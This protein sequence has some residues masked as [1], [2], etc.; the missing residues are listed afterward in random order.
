MSVSTQ[1]LTRPL[2]AV[3]DPAPETADVAYLEGFDRFDHIACRSCGWQFPAP[4]GAAMLF[5]LKGPC[6]NCG[7]EFELILGND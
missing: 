6:P 1:P 3:A 4:E 5:A 2:P 7:G